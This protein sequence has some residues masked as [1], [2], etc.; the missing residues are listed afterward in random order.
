MNSRGAQDRYLF[1]P[2]VIAQ[3]FYH[4]LLA[5][6]PTALFSDSRRMVGLQAQT[7]FR[8]DPLRDIKL[9]AINGAFAAAGIN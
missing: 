1:A 8:N 2:V 5:L 7:I 9:N 3:L 6:G 4:A